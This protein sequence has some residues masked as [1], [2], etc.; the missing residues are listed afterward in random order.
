[1]GPGR[2]LHARLQY[3]ALA[4]LVLLAT[5]TCGAADH[6]HA[7]NP[8]GKAA[9]P[10]APLNLS[11]GDVTRYFDAAELATP[12][13]ESVLEEI[14]VNGQRPEPLPER[15]VIPQAL[16]ALIY[17]ATNPLDAWRILVPD[18]NLEIPERSEDDTRDPPGA[19]RGRIL[20]PGAIYD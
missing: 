20:E 10:A 6:P 7:P 19:F 5:S 3:V 17:A 15:R 16:G 18:P 12:L 13:P 9:N 11:L 1:M 2:L 4:A 8:A 14:I